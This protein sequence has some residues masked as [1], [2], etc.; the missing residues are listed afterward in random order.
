MLSQNK[1][2][3]FLDLDPYLNLLKG[4][5]NYY[6]YNY[7]WFLIPELFRKLNYVNDVLK[8]RSN[9]FVFKYRVK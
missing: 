4:Q 5:N 6:L 3:K 1:K 7:L 9:R 8:I 2:T